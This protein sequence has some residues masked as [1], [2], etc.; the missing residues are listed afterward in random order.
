MLQFPHQ[1]EPEQIAPLAPY[2]RLFGVFQEAGDWLDRLGVRSVGAL[3]DAIETGRLPEISLVAEALHEGRIAQIAAEIRAR[4][5]KVVLVAGPSSSGKTTFSKRLAV[6]LLAMGRHPFPIG[7]DDFFLNREATPR[8]EHGQLD[9]EHIGALDLPLLER[10]LLAL[11]RGDSVEMPHYDFRAGRRRPGPTVALGDDDILI[12]EGIHGLNPR[13]LPRL[14]K[15]QLYRIYVSAL[16]QLNLNRHNRVSTTDCRL[17]RRLVRDTRTRGYRP[18]Q[19]IGRWPSVERGE[20]RDIFPFQENA[21]AI[22]NA[23]LVHE[24]A[25]LRP[26]AEPLLL[27]IRPE[28]PEFVEANRLLSLLQWFQPATPEPVPDNSILREFIGGSILERFRLW[29]DRDYEPSQA[30]G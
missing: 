2:P 29:T 9:F 14:P 13:L 19:T 11:L 27:Q 8:D 5:I 17:I 12:L 18:R 3:N 24:L 23:A 15:Q 20:K 30:N 26:F 4:P 21:D 22:F 7:L 10:R 25:V 1:Q 6:Q 28:D 16:T